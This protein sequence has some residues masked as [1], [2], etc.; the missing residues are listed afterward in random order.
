MEACSS[1][2]TSKLPIRS[3]HKESLK[4]LTLFALP[5]R[6]FSKNRKV[7]TRKRRIKVT[8][9]EMNRV[10]KLPSELRYSLRYG[11]TIILSSSC[12][13]LYKLKQS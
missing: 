11:I 13:R 4:T 12:T 8:S 2:I 3:I 9:I 10:Q 1:V 7:V 5:L 6:F